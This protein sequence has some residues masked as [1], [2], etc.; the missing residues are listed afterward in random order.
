MQYKVNGYA[1]L[2]ETMP[3]LKRHK[4]PSY[5]KTP[6]KHLAYA[7][8]DNE[9]KRAGGRKRTSRESFVFVIIGVFRSSP[10]AFPAPALSLTA[11][12]KLASL[13][14]FAPASGAVIIAHG[15][16]FAIFCP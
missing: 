16:K 11:S 2:M 8:Q 7:K 3:P 4:M 5:M 6:Y 15:N 12:S 9:K 13:G 14:S 10:A 1:T